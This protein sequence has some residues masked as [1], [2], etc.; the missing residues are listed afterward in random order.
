MDAW[1]E[2]LA[3]ASHGLPHALGHGLRLWFIEIDW[4]GEIPTQLTSFSERQ[5]AQAMPDVMQARRFLVGRAALRSLLHLHYELQETDAEFAVSAT[6]KPYLPGRRIRFNL[7]RSGAALLVGIDDGQEVG[8]DLE[9]LHAVTDVDALAQFCLMPAERAR[10]HMAGGSE[11]VL[12]R[13]WTRKE[14]CA[15]AIGLGLAISFNAFAPG[16]S[17]PGLPSEARLRAGRTTWTLYATSLTAP[18]G[19]VAAAARSAH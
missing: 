4:D 15:K 10:W 12:L 14:A 7:S 16:L 19:Y 1:L 8:V 2:R 6:G 3:R 9:R 13:Y 5:R 11:C 17:L 18:N